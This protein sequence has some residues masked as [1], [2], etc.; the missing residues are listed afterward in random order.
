MCLLDPSG[1]KE[2]L[3]AMATLTHHTSVDQDDPPVFW[4]SQGG[5]VPPNTFP[6]GG[7]GHP[8]WSSFWLSRS[9]NT[10]E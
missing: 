3:V 9:N 2:D 10:F 6:H 1:S 4:A 8:P 5:P 7:V